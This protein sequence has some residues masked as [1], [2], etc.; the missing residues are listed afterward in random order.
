VFHADRGTDGR[1]DMPRLV[2][3]F[4]SVANAPKNESCHFIY[5][6][7]TL[8][9]KEL[10]SGGSFVTSISLELRGRERGSVLATVRFLFGF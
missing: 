2:V 6:G 8:M 1:T 3:V 7:V 5:T 9:T 10:I 4:R